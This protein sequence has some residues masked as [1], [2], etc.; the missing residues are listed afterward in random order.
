M[1]DNFQLTK[2]QKNYIKENMGVDDFS[3]LKICFEVNSIDTNGVSEEFTN[4]SVKLS[5]DICPC[6]PDYVNWR[7]SCC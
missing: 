4:K 3:K 1:E 6:P 2:K 7:A 5:F